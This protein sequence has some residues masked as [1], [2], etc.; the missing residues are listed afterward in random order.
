MAR[1]WDDVATTAA[2]SANA[3]GYDARGSSV[4]AR[5]AND[6]DAAA[7]TVPA[8]ATAVPTAAAYDVSTATNVWRRTPTLFS[9]VK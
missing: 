1:D 2:A 5:P 7:T 6:A 3:H 8:A 4:W 9:E